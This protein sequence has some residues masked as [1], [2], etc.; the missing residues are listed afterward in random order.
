[1]SA[2][3]APH[4]LNRLLVAEHDDPFSILGLHKVGFQLVLR[5]FRPEASSLAVL[6][7]QNPSRRFA[8]DRVAKEGFFE[9]VIGEDAPRFDYLLEVTTWKGETVQFAD[10]YSFGP[11]LG[12]LDM[13][14][15]KEGNHFK[16]YEKLGAHLVSINGCA[17]VSFAVWAPKAQ[18]V[19]V[20]GDFNGWDGR[21]HPMRHRMEAGVWEI[22]V[23]G[24][25]EGAHYKFEICN[26]FGQKVLKSDPFA[27]YGQHSLKTA[28]LV[29]D[30]DRFGWSDQAW[31]EARDRKQ[32][33]REPVSVYEVHLGSWARVPEEN[34]RYLVVAA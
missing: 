17:G 7:R 31:M 1:M 33:Q 2:T 25:C 27:F 26:C 19:S 20:V 21:I 3:I 24:V 11:I 9:A 34:N 15:L 8:A 22:F 28:S 29:F 10:P 13:L 18:R 6:D 14:L 12:E 32:W 16:I 5:A 4:D 23:P 30:L